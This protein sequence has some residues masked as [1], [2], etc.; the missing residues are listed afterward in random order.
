MPSHLV[1]EH[2][3]LFYGWQ[4]GQQFIAGAAKAM[5]RLLIDIA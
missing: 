2:G 5:R 4:N 3:G 1:R